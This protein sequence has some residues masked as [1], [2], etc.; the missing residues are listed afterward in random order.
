MKKNILI[1]VMLLT[2][3]QAKAQSNQNEKCKEYIVASN[4]TV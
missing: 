2:T 1:M 3:I 4:Q